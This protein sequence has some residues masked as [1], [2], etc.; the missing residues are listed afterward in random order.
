MHSAFLRLAISLL[1]GL[2][3]LLVNSTLTRESLHQRRL[4]RHVTEVRARRHARSLSELPWC[5]KQT[6]CRYVAAVLNF[7]PY[8]KN[9]SIITERGILF[10]EII[11][12]VDSECLGMISFPDHTTCCLE[13]LFVNTLDEI[14]ELVKAKK[15][16]LAFPIQVETKEKLKDI[17]YV[18]LVRVYVAKGSSLIVNTKHCEVESRE[19]LLTSI[20]SQWPILA[21]I[22][23]LSGISGVIIWLLE[24]KANKSQFSSSF[25]AGSPEGFWWAIVSLTTVGCGDKTPKTFLGRVYEIIWVLVGAIMM[26]LFTAFFTNAMQAALDGT[27]CQDINSKDVGVWIVNSEIKRFAVEEFDANIV[28]FD[29]IAEMQQNIS[30]GAIGRVL[31]DRDSAFDFLS[32]SKLKRNRQI[33][34]IRNIDYPM[35]YFLVHV[36][37]S[38]NAVS[39]SED[40][41]SEMTMSQTL[42]DTELKQEDEDVIEEKEFPSDEDVRSQIASCGPRLKELSQ[43]IVGAT[44]QRALEQVIPAALQ[45]ASLS[46]EMEG[47]FS[48]GS[49][50]T[51][52]M[53]F[54][55]VGILFSLVLVGILWEIFTKCVASNRSRRELKGSPCLHRHSDKGNLIPMNKRFSMMQSFLEIEERLKEFTADLQKMKEEYAGTMANGV[56]FRDSRQRSDDMNSVEKRRSFFDILNGKNKNPETTI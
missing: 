35:D 55:L 25:T 9:T 53:L 16:D 23:L 54:C 56:L 8:V 13:T 15:V 34:L 45:T 28:K 1:I 36:D 4:K 50:M 6:S 11:N 29:S 48:T 18:T 17:P 31:V 39:T 20:T 32:G 26:S 14:I 46:N 43:D 30:D 33:R 24:H 5:I 49:K 19:Q 37:R 10:S 27:K 12:I 3:S 7:P 51:S 41:M 42:K 44:K 40:E 47:L 2:E 38:S 22:I 21:C 52:F